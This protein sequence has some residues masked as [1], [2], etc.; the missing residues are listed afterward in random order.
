MQKVSLAA[1][2]GQQVDRAAGAGGWHTA[3]TVYGGHEKVLRQTVIGMSQ[4][5]RR[6]STRTR[7]RRQCRCSTVG[8]A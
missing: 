2:A 4:G 5:A 6:S 1:L 8:F 7:A 3:D